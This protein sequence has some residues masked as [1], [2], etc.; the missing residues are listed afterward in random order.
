MI[1]TKKLS[2][3]F[4]RAFHGGVERG[5]NEN[6]EELGT[7]CGNR[8]MYQ[9]RHKASFERFPETVAFLLARDTKATSNRVDGENDR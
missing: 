1:D 9:N 8:Q 2:L 6:S 5:N 3:F 4:S 7:I